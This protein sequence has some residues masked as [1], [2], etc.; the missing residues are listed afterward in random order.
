MEEIRTHLKAGYQAVYD[1]D[2][3]G[4]FDSIPHERLLACVRMRVA[5]RSVLGLIQQWLEAPVVESSR[6]AGGTPTVSRTRKGTPQG[7]VISPLLAN[8]YLHW[9]DHMFHR[10]TGPARWA[11][12]K[13]IR[14]ADDFVV[15]ARSQGPRLTGFIE[16]KLEGWLG[17]EINR[18]KTRIVCLKEE[19]ASLDF[20]GFTFRYERDRFG[21]GHRFLNVAPSKKA[22]Q[23]ERAKLHELT[24]GRQ[25]WKPIPTLIGEINRQIRSWAAYFR[26]GYPSRSFGDLDGYVRTRMWNHLRR[27]S[28][29]G[30]RAPQGVSSYRHLRSLGLQPVR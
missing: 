30:Y 22:L 19:R 7:G 9:F 16:S 23:R 13:L 28:Q 25:N 3:K 29:R 2:L 1:A 18:E 6:E 20:L 26:F 27:R 5:D 17:L 15:L 24:C 21:R 8:L 14:Y 11:N 10:P 4:Y 12:A